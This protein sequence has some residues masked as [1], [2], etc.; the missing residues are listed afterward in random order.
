MKTIYL[1]EEN[2]WDLI[3]AVVA[4]N[5]D[6]SFFDKEMKEDLVKAYKSIVEINGDVLRDLAK[7]VGFYHRLEHRN[8]QANSDPDEG[9]DPNHIFHSLER[10]KTAFKLE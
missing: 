7:V 5:M 2:D 8:L 6:S 10:L 9:S 4:E 1:A 3:F